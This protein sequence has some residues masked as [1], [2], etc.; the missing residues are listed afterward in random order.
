MGLYVSRHDDSIDF[1]VGKGF[2]TGASIEEWRK[3]FADHKLLVLGPASVDGQPW[4]RRG[5]FP[6]MGVTARSVTRVALTH[7][8][9]APDVMD[10]VRGGFVIWTYA[11]R[12]LQAA[13]AYDATGRELERVDISHIDLGKVCRDARGCPPGKWD[14]APGPPDP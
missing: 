8:S 14:L 3:Q 13:I 10:G 6:L 12:P 7:P 9:G 4:D 1:A 11:R 5:R 2:G